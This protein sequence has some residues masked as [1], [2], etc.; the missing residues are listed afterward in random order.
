[1]G[2][3]GSGSGNRFA[4]KTDELRKVDLADFKR[5]WFEPG[6]NGTCRWSRGGRETASIGYRLRANYMELH[7]TVTRQGE[8]LRVDERFDFAFTD[9]PFGGQRRW[10]VCRSCNSR[11]RVLYGGAYFRC[12]KCYEA[13]YPSQYEFIRIPALAKA[14]RA[15]HK[16]GGEPGFIHGLPAKP[17]G[18]HWQTYRRLQRQD[19]AASDALNMALYQKMQRFSR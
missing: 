12:R 8:E 4:T 5:H 9:Q 16:L 11:C 19:W 13:T 3:W 18:M 6:F 14:E 2:G 10:I 7:Y 1:M 17:K 15:R